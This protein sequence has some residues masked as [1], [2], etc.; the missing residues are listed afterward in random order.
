MVGHTQTQLE[1][2]VFRAQVFVEE[3]QKRIAAQRV[4][5]A[6]LDRNGGWQAHE[7]KQFL[8]TME[9]TQSLQIAHLDLLRRE[10]HEM[11]GSRLL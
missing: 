6:A 10:L 9:V 11:I 8:K 3:G 5:V 2:L 7:S 4:R 1:E